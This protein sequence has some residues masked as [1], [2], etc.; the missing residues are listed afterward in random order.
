VETLEAGLVLTGSE[1]KSL[2]QAR[3]HINDA[4]VVPVDGSLSLINMQ[5]DRYEN[6]GHFNH[7]E[8]RSRKLLLHKK[9][10]EQ[11]ISKIKEKRMTVIALKLYFNERGRIK[12][13]LGIARGKQKADRREDEKKREAN[14]E[15][16]RALK[17][18]NKRA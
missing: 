5:I 6:A 10:I 9:E 8:T 12:V 3:A 1:V 13:L 11:I 17:D 16:Q 14:L 2:R 15:I 18:H 7:E 4:Y